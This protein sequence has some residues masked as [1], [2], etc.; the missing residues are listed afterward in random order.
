MLKTQSKI[1]IGEI[2]KY[3][4]IQIEGIKNIGQEFRNHLSFANSLFL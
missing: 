1:L 3:N 2:L 4:K